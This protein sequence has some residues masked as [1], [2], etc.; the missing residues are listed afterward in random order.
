M[1]ECFFPTSDDEIGPWQEAFDALPSTPIFLMSG[2]IIHLMSYEER[3]I[4]AMPGLEAVRGLSSFTDVA[5]NVELGEM[6]CKTT[7]SQ[8]HARR[9]KGQCCKMLQENLKL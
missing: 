1:D 8:L 4:T 9:G 2:D 5:L 7:D 6:I 3:L